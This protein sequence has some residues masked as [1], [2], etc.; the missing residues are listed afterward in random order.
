MNN[1]IYYISLFKRYID[2]NR[3]ISIQDYPSY[4]YDGRNNYT[5]IPVH[6]ELSE[7]ELKLNLN[8]VF[9]RNIDRYTKYVNVVDKATGEVIENKNVLMSVNNNIYDSCDYKLVRWSYGYDIKKILE[10]KDILFVHEVNES[11][12]EL[13]N[14]WKKYKEGEK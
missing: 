1:R 2:L 10:H 11:I 14:A 9:E 7:Q 8:E 5:C 6:L 13:I 4:Y 3:I 12:K